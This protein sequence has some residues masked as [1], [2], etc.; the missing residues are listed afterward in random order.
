MSNKSGLLSKSEKTHRGT[1]QFAM[2]YENGAV[3]FIFL[4]ANRHVDEEFVK[5]LK[6][7]LTEKRLPS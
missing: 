1:N 5:H 4:V 7:S 6:Y 3:N 2:N